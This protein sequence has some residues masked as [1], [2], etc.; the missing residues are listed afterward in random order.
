MEYISDISNFM[1]KAFV[2]ILPYILISI[3]FSVFINLSGKSVKVGAWFQK[4]PLL[5]IVAAVLFGSLSPLC[6][7]TVIPV[8]YSLLLSGVPLGPVMAFWL[9]SPSMDPEVFFLSLAKIGTSLSV[10]RLGTTF[11]LSFGGGLLTHYLDSKGF[12]GSDYLRQN[13][14]YASFSIRRL[15]KRLSGKSQAKP[16]ASCCQPAKPTSAQPTSSDEETSCCS[17]PTQ[18]ESLTR[19]I[20]KESVKMTIFI[21]KFIL[22][23]LFL[24]ALIDLYLPETFI[25]SML[26][27]RGW[28]E[29]SLSALFGVPFYTNS[30]AALGIVAGLMLKGLS[31]AAALAFL[32]AGPT[33]T[34]PAMTAVFCITRKRVFFVY[35]AIVFA[36]AILLS[37][38][39]ALL[40]LQFNLTVLPEH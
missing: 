38:L 13:P 26:S 6:S 4:K 14:N 1:I 30:L 22:L 9:S 25:P 19:R 32:I 12:F 21:M 37:S 11:L 18:T 27:G 3:P 35:L 28:L 5:A 34:L 7:C 24:E 20:V 33:T 2:R 10:A 17:G 36:G 31:G 16:T 40:D 39:Y 23:A 15:I 8:I 29:I